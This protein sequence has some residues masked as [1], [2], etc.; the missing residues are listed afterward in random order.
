MSRTRPTLLGILG[1]LLDSSI[2]AYSSIQLSGSGA[3]T[4]RWRPRTLSG[5]AGVSLVSHKSILESLPEG[6]RITRVVLTQTCRAMNI[7]TLEMDGP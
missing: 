2:L 6:P 7:R 1:N 4:A 5:P 3:G